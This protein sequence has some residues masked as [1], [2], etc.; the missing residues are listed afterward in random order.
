MLTLRSITGGNLCEI[1]C[2]RF[3]TN[4]CKGQ[5]YIS[6]RKMIVRA[7]LI[8]SQTREKEK[9][10][11]FF[12]GNQHVLMPI[13]SSFGSH[14]KYWTILY[15]NTFSFLSILWKKKTTFW[16]TIYL[17]VY[18]LIYLYVYLF[19]TWEGVTPQLTILSCFDVFGWISYNKLSA[20]SICSTFC[21]ILN[22][23]F[24]LH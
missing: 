1:N 3:S 19:I 13:R 12:M 22:C 4:S 17:F 21:S 14:L 7:A 6:K 9:R 15:S 5:S 2:V 8:D 16:L 10:I 23:W 18:L 20:L 11:V 24:L